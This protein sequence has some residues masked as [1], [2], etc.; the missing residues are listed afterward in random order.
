MTQPRTLKLTVPP[1]IVSG[2]HSTRCH[3]EAGNKRRPTILSVYL[4]IVKPP[5][6]SY[7]TCYIKYHSLYTA[8][9]G[10]KRAH[11]YYIHRRSVVLV[12]AAVLWL[13]RF[14]NNCEF[15]GISSAFTSSLCWRIFLQIIVSSR[16]S[17]D[18]RVVALF[19][20]LFC[21]SSDKI[22]K[23]FFKYISAFLDRTGNF[24]FW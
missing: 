22:G 18:D 10:R 2:F 9:C 15:S 23:F 16:I 19:S 12:L 20:F 24:N 6:V 14:S 5:R 13:C 1:M 21:G 11:S 17:N 4:F 7:I 8:V 3:N